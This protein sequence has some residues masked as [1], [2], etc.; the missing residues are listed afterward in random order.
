[1]RTAVNFLSLLICFTGLLF[2]PIAA[3]TQ[4]GAEFVG[5]QDLG[6]RDAQLSPDGFTMAI[7]TYDANLGESVIR[8][9][10]WDGA[11]WQEQGDG[12]R[13]SGP[14]SVFSFSQDGT[15]IIVAHEG[16]NE[17]S[18]SN[19]TIQTFL[20][21]IQGFS[22][23]NIVHTELP[24]WRLRD[25]H[26]YF[27]ANDPKI[28]VGLTCSVHTFV[29]DRSAGNP[30]WEEAPSLAIS[31]GC[32]FNGQSTSLSADGNRLSFYISSPNEGSRFGVFDW[33]DDA[34]VPL[35]GDLPSNVNADDVALSGDGQRLAISYA[36]DFDRDGSV[37]IIYD[38]QGQEWVQLGEPILNPIPGSVDI[39]GG[40]SFT[41]EYL[42]Y[43][44]LFN[45]P[46]PGAPA[47]AGCM[48]LFR[49][50]ENEWV[51]FGEIVCGDID[52]D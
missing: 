37:I 14:Y 48:Q 6:I 8:V 10:L 11:Q 51:P 7:R 9:Y 20:W 21:D 28:V 34:W 13:H 31:N 18:L 33:V 44:K 17:N 46:F 5:E 40:L 38:R 2:H 25:V 29:Y 22:V 36:D 47:F 19:T 26:F 45:E 1:M 16:I 42:W 41:G 50:Y 52:S 39:L 24:P 3:Q 43:G 49:F 30:I 32:Y 12:F 35:P 15:N 23:L 4:L 27:D